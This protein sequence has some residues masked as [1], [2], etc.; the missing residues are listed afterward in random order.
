MLPNLRRCFYKKKENPR[1]NEGFNLNQPKPM[2]KPL[3]F[4]VDKC[5]LLFSIDKFI[6]KKVDKKFTKI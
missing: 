4:Y 1:R 2:K 3:A 5:R 6:F